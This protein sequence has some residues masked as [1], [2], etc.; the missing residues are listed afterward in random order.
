ME[1]SKKGEI[2]KWQNR[3]KCFVIVICD[4]IQMA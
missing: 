1:K 3:K 2:G 4:A